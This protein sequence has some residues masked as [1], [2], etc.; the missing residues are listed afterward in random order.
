MEINKK[1]IIDIIMCVYDKNINS[2]ILYI[3]D[4]SSLIIKEKTGYGCN[5]EIIDDYVTAYIYCKDPKL[6]WEKI[7]FNLKS[8]I[9][10]YKVN[11]LI[12]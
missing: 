10:D 2:S 7:T 8:E 12:Q 1:Y 3:L 4:E 11:K 6:F 5:M 9:R